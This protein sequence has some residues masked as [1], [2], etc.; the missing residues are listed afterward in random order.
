MISVIIPVYNAEKTLK[1]CVLSVINQT[2]TDF[3]VLIINDGST[4]K[5]QDLCNEF[6]SLDARIKIFKNQI[7]GVSSARN[8]GISKAVGDFIFF[9]DSDDW[10]EVRALEFLLT[11]II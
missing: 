4:D 3:E 1:K 11:K 2:Y 9:L 10:L 6:A 7:K 5:T 8:T